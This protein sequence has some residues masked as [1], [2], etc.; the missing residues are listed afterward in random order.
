M[1]VQLSAIGTHCGAPSTG[2][3]V[4]L[5]LIRM[6]EIAVGLIEATASVSLAGAAKVYEFPL[7]TKTTALTERPSSSANGD[8]YSQQLS[9]SYLAVNNTELAEWADEQGLKRW[10]A[11]LSNHNGGCLF[12]R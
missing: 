8:S 12:G 6:D 4:R 10:V 2:Y 5:L 7:R 11:H 1:I 3:L 9:L